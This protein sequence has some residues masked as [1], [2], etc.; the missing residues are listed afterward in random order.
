MPSVL[1]NGNR[2]PERRATIPVLDR[3]VMPGLGL[4]ETLR[5]YGGRPFALREHLRR[6][7]A[8]ARRLGL[9]CPFADRSL[10]RA[11]DGLIEANRVR[12]G[13]L[14]VLLTSGAPRI[15]PS[16]IVMT[17]RLPRL[18]RGARRRGVRVSI[19]PG[20]RN[21]DRLLA[22]IKSLNYLEPRLLRDRAR[23]GGAFEAIYA[24]AKGRLL[25]GTSSNLFAVI[26]G[27]V[28]TPPEHGILP[29]I[30]R[31]RIIRL[32]GRVRLRPLTRSDLMRAEEVFL[33]NALIEVLPVRQVGPVRIPGTA[34]MVARDLQARYRA[35]VGRERSV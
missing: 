23:A 5:I 35:C 7:R 6:M 16:V 20:T 33:T 10:A 2:I 28:V 32:L 17:P 8:G 27:H 26:R 24:D 11:I 30:T 12:S 34:F 4:F 19:V 15:R 25:E 13:V 9:R 18:P 14:R 31:A 3:A 21:P 1:L 29:G 22:G